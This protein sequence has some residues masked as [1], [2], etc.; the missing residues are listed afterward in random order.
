MTV[1]LYWT[2]IMQYR[3][4][5]DLSVKLFFALYKSKEVD[6]APYRYSYAISILSVSDIKGCSA[7]FNFAY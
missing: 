7:A 2:I 1:D 3:E 4:S 6:N 5:K